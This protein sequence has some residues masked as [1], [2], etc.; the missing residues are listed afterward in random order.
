MLLTWFFAI[1]WWM[2]AVAV[3]LTFF[4][5]AVAARAGAETGINPI[6]ALGKVTQLT[7]GV[8]GAG[9]HRR[10]TS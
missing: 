6:G 3:V 10:R 7:F 4:L 9:Q 1:H 5:A 8:A 2:G